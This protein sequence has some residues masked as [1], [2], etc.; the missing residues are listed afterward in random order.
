MPTKYKTVRVY[1][2]SYNH[3]IEKKL[4]I[5]KRWKH[6]T[7]QNRRVKITK[8][9]DTLLKR[10]ITIWNDGDLKYYMTKHKR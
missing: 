4:A 3:L 1:N 7:G 2:D 10:Q 5:E 6:L 8:L 9:V